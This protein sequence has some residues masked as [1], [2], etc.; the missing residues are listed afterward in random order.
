MTR[1]I[2]QWIS[3]ME[4]TATCWN[5]TLQEKTGMGYIDLAAKVSGNSKEDIKAASKTCK[6]AVVPITAGLGTIDTFSKSVAAIPTAM[7]F[8][9]FITTA[10][11]VSG[12]LEAYEKNA[13]IIYM[14][15]DDR[16]I[17]LNIKNNKIGENN[18]AT[19]NGFIEVLEALG[20][21]LSGQ[22]AL[23][24]GYGIVG[25]T[26]AKALAKKSAKVTVYDKN[27]RKDLLIKSDG[28]KVLGSIEAMS[29][30]KYVADATSEGP[31]I[32]KDMLNEEAVL[33]APGIP[34]SL[35][36]SAKAKFADRYVH[37]LLE[38]GTAVMLGL[39]I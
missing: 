18:F 5:K 19:A 7:G 38:I 9:T 32:T 17:A 27:S 6:V 13:E 12:I 35:D 26:M 4:D 11:D 1:L 31:W 23:V 3:T 25:Q 30:F 36:G 8:E 14:A 16:Y 34:F 24:L 39:A 21:T 29:S 15:D 33:A 2:T 20:G 22:D 28:Y 37:D 10:S